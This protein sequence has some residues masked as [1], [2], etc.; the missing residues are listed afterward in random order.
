MQDYPISF[1]LHKKLR[2][3]SEAGVYA[4]SD[5]VLINITLYCT[6][7][8]IPT[9]SDCLRSLQVDTCIHPLDVEIH[10]ICLGIQL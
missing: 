3:T 6:Y 9:D 4:S 7:A 1:S 10:D 2:G 5:G 8:Q